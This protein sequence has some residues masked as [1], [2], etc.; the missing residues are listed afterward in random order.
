MVEGTDRQTVGDSAATT[1][2]PL[3]SRIAGR[4]SD[5]SK[6][7][8]RWWWPPDPSEVGDRPNWQELHDEAS[9]TIRRVMLTIVGYCFF[10]ILTLGTPDALLVENN[11]KIKLPFANTDIDFSNFLIVGPIVLI[12]LV[13]YMHIFIAYWRNIPPG[14]VTQPLPFVFNMP[15][16]FA[17]LLTG[18]LF[19]WLAPLVMLIFVWKA[20]GLADL[21]LLLLMTALVTTVL[22]W[23]EIRY[24]PAAHR[25]GWR[26]ASL[27]VVLVVLVTVSVK[28]I[29]ERSVEHGPT[30][31]GF[32]SDVAEPIVVAAMPEWVR[33]ADTQIAVAPAAPVSLTEPTTTEPSEAP[34]QIVQMQQ[35]PLTRGLSLAKADLREADLVSR[36]LE[37]ADLRGADLTG[38]SLRGEE[39][40]LKNF[41]MANLEG[42]DLSDTT[43]TNVSFFRANLKGAYLVGAKLRRVI[44]A[45]A[46]LRSVDFT[47]AEFS[48]TFISSADI[49]GAI[50]LDCA[51]LKKMP[52]WESTQRDPQLACG[53]PIPEPLAVA[54]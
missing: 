52:G 12:G 51:Q 7:P 23:L 29:W 8:R 22:V 34:Q 3:I 17:Q 31:I 35:R 27:W 11:N 18:F 42:A 21:P 36:D 25:R 43:L 6:W 26:Y 38:I 39:K 16:R 54:K 41:N 14:M 40:A 45:G 2:A 20:S 13:I 30:L 19:Y 33:E 48:E 10:C 46:D 28:F 9:K 15:G 44:F 32:A 47:E 37:R 4:L 49:R 1:E 24:R 5:D 50:G 53:E